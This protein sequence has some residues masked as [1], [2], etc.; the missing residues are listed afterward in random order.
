TNGA[1]IVIAGGAPFLTARAAIGTDVRGDRHVRAGRQDGRLLPWRTVMCRGSSARSHD[2]SCRALRER[3]RASAP[4]V[5]PAG[6]FEDCPASASTQLGPAS[7]PTETI[8]P[9]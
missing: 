8:V 2:R 7:S 3:G 1:A 6:A 4:P 5:C 9:S